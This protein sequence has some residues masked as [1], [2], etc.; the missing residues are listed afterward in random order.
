MQLTQ[1]QH[2]RPAKRLIST[3]DMPLATWLEIRTQGIGASDAGAAIGINPYL[4]PLELWML[5]THRINPSAQVESSNGKAPTYWGHVLEPIVAQEYSKQTGNKVRRVNAI[6][7][8]P[9]TDKHWMLANLD[10]A[11]CSN[12]DVQILECKTA[13]EYGAK[14]WRNGVPTYVRCQVLHQLA[15][16]GKQAADVCVLICGQELQIH[17]IQRD[18]A[19]IT[20]LIEKERAFWRCVET[21]TPPQTDATDSCDRA[22]KQLYPKDIHT[23][24]DC[25]NNSD[26]NTTFDEL[27]AIGNQLKRLKT[28]EAKL[29]HELQAAM[30]DAQKARFSHGLATWKASADKL[31][32][33]TE[34]LLNDQPSLM[35]RYSLTKHGSRRFNI[36]PS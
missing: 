11:V 29:K 25:S 30:K 1:I 31:Q 20:D 7:Q 10:Y 34:T 5:K 27:V 28:S 36:Y 14:C 33:D 21:N 22:L 12:Q 13:G 6:L 35:K 4:S 23:S 15:V 3:K 24:I 26:L 16:T 9:D 17:R 18:D 32:L 19:E 2:R 8:H